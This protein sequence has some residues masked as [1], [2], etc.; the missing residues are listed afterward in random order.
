MSLFRIEPNEVS[1]ELL[2]KVKKGKTCPTNL[3]FAQKEGGSVFC[4]H[5]RQGSVTDPS[6]TA[7]RNF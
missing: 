3:F 4:S 7:T 6:A 2:E 5:D 1:F